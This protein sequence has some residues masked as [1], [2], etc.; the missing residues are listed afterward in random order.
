MLRSRQRSLDTKG[1]EGLAG[2]SDKLGFGFSPNGDHIALLGE[3]K[4]RVNLT[5]GPVTTSFGQFKPDAP[6]AKGFHNVEDQGIPRS[7]AALTGQG[8]DAMEKLANDD[9]GDR[10]LAA[11]ASSLKAVNEIFRVSPRRT[12]PA[13]APADLS[14]DR[15]ESEDELAVK[16]M[17]VVSQG[18]DDANGQFRLEND[19]LRVAK[20]DG[21]AF[22]EDP[23]Y[24]SITTTLEGLAE[25]LRP[26]G[27][28]A[29]FISPLVDA[30]L[31]GRKPV[32][33]TS[34]PL[35][36]CL[37]G[38][39]VSTGVVDEWGRVYRQ[40]QGQA[41]FYRG[42]YIADGSVIPTALGV[43]PSLTISAVSL[44]IADK[45][46]AEWDEIP[47]KKPRAAAPLQCNT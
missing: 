45:V 5:T 23:I 44:R 18:K 37:M 41:A 6:Q 32:V 1:A 2:L 19:R 27:S 11:L 46:L 24:A 4:E 43:N 7:L 31:P 21:K 12:Y 39:S 29:R 15:P 14:S 26:E 17:C 25:Q 8:F 40:A 9:A 13:S 16:I 42:L 33:L 38:D 22:H 36:G 47:A 30:V 28:K 3:T 34:H 10:Y 35:G 20:T